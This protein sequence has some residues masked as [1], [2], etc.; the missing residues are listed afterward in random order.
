[1]VDCRLFLSEPAIARGVVYTANGTQLEARRESDGILL[2]SWSPSETNV[3]PFAA[4]SPSPNV[5]VTDNLV[6]VSTVSNVYAI[7]IATRTKVW[8][9]PCGGR[10]ALSRNGV[11]YIAPLIGVPTVAEGTLTAINLR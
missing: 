6:F 3:A 5:I 11:L 1:M 8:S 9:F 4:G 10:I 2:W 7:D